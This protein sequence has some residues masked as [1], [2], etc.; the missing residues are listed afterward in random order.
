MKKPTHRNGLS[1][2]RVATRCAFAKRPLSAAFAFARQQTHVRR[3]D[4]HHIFFSR[5]FSFFMLLL[6]PLALL[7]EKIGT[8]QDTKWIGWAFI[9]G[10]EG[11]HCC[12]QIEAIAFD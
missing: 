2:L 11:G 9:A 7:F 1:Q 3:V 6:V 4:R 5:H 12:T 10:V 8:L